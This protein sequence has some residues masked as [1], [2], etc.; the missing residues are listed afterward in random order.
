MAFLQP[1]GR[2]VVF[3]GDTEIGRSSLIA[4]CMADKPFLDNP[5]PFIWR[6]SFVH[7]VTDLESAEPPC[8]PEA[9]STKSTT[10]KKKVFRGI[11]QTRL[12]IINVAEK[13]APKFRPYLYSYATAVVFCFSIGNESS[14]ENIK[15]KVNHP[16]LTTHLR[17]MRANL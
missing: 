6:P 5:P 2:R 9:T 3:V 8:I 12:H 11:R 13:E 17:A 4:V 15:N 14:F 1:L 10:S 7:L 16:H